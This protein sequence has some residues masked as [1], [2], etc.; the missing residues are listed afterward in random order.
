VWERFG[1]RKSPRRFAKK[2][3]IVDEFSAGIHF[4]IWNPTVAVKGQGL[5]PSP[6]PRLLSP[7]EQVM[8]KSAEG[9]SSVSKGRTR[10]TEQGPGVLDLFAEEGAPGSLSNS[11]LGKPLPSEGA[12]L[13]GQKRMFEPEPTASVPKSTPPSAVA[14]KQERGGTSA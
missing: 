7:A 6:P 9:A 5:L 3:C 1:Q 4:L 14:R 13:S 11:H 12:I 2:T 8:S 10:L